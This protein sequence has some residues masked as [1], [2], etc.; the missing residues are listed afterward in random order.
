MVILRFAASTAR[1]RLVR[2]LSS[3]F[4]RADGSR[5]R[6]ISISNCVLRNSSRVSAS[7]AAELH[8]LGGDG[9]AVHDGNRPRHRV[10]C[11]GGR[12]AGN[13]DNENDLEIFEPGRTCRLPKARRFG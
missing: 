10:L 7:A 4:S 8:F 11:V 5:S 13:E 9:D 1:T 12:A 6:F 2:I 3:A